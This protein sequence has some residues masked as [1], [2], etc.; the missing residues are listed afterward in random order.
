MFMIKFHKLQF[1][2]GFL[3][4]MSACWVRQLQRSCC[5]NKIFVYNLS[6][7][8]DYGSDEL[9][10]AK[11]G[12]VHGTAVLDE[13]CGLTLH[14]ALA[15]ALFAGRGAAAG[16]AVVMDA[17]HGPLAIHMLRAGI[18]LHSLQALGALQRQT[19]RL[20]G[21]RGSM[22]GA[23]ARR[24]FRFVFAV[25]VERLYAA[26]V[27]GQAS[28][29]QGLRLVLAGRVTATFQTKGGDERRVPLVYL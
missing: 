16:A 21:R 26:H 1:N 19:Q 28:W 11:G 13:S 15:L 10:P 4:H 20:L 24:G 2:L 17:L 9:V 7:S 8:G 5:S 29:T 22:D 14:L 27:A 18:Q 25:K 3:L 12:C 23:A 6:P